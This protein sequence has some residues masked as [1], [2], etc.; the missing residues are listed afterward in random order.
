[1]RRHLFIVWMLAIAL[2]VGLTAPRAVRAVEDSRPNILFCLADDWGWPHAGVYGDPVVKTPTF[3]RLAREGVLFDNAYV[4]SPSCTP[5]RNAA[6]TG[7]YHWRLEEGG[8][9]WSSLAPKYKLFPYLLR[10]AGYEI[11]H[12]RKAWGPG[13]WR[14]LGREEDPAGP[15]FKSF[16]DFLK[17][18][19]KGKPFCFWFGTS[20]PHR[21]YDPGSGKRSGMDVNA[22][23]LPADLPDDEVVRNDVA[24]YYFE[25][26]RWDSDVAKAVAMLEAAGELDNTII[27]MSG[28]H[29]MPL[30]RHKCHLYDSGVRVPMAIRWGAR[31]KAGR[32][33]TDFVSFTDLAPTFLEAANVRI[34]DEMTGRSLMPVLTSEKSGRVVAS[35]DHV[36]TGRER[37]A[38][39]QEKPNPGGYP[40]RAIRTDG[41]LYI[42]NFEPDRWPAGCPDPAL[43]FN[44]NACGDCDGGPTKDFMLAHR[45]DPR[46]GR[47]VSLAFDKRPAEELYD[48]SR[49][50][51]Q[52]HNIAEDPFYADIKRTLAMQLMAELK[53]TE[54]PRVVGGGEAFDHYPYY[55]RGG[56][57]H[58]TP[59]GK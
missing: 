27:V 7:Q 10:D 28:D 18:R 55:G 23:K 2:G 51:D 59:K 12:W 15:S 40:M 34:P 52:L 33:V 50:P 44:G 36:L 4:S 19:T 57:K 32:R 46:F 29:G 49:D 39:G 42:Y 5:C 22:I 54:D 43:S 1:M 17:S 16:D 9:L 6:L 47:L 21:P 25:V 20:D 48:L 31:V 58:T 30:P 13:D 41:F 11:G 56:V 8:N 53:S 45:D 24:D 38:Q 37:H 35:R 3:D 26:Q 14:A